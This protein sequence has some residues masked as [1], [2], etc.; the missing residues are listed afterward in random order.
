LRACAI[1]NAVPPQYILAAKKFGNMQTRV[2]NMVL[3]KSIFPQIDRMFIDWKRTDPGEV[4]EDLTSKQQH[5]VWY[6]TF[7]AVPQATTKVM[8]GTI[9]SAGLGSTDEEQERLGMLGQC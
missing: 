5:A 4:F 1:D 9:G 2:Q 8:W 7:D 6:E 3:D